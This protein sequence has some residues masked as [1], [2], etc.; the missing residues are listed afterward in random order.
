[1]LPLDRPGGGGET[2]LLR[3]VNSRDGMTADHVELDEQVISELVVRLSGINGVSA[4]LYDVTDKPPA[5]I[6]LE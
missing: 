3:P 5:T 4:I 6:E 1:L 2:V